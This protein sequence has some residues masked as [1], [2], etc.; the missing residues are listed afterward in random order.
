MGLFQDY[1]GK[2]IISSLGT[3]WSKQISMSQFSIHDLSHIHV[4]DVL[5]IEND[6]D[7]AAYVPELQL[8][9]GDLDFFQNQFVIQHIKLENATINLLKDKGEEKYNFQFLFKKSQNE[10]DIISNYHVL[11]ENVELINCVFN[12]R[13]L[14]NKNYTQTFDYQFFN[15]SNINGLFNNFSISNKGIF[16]PKNRLFFL[17]D[18][19]IDVR[20]LY[21]EFTLDY[22][23]IFVENIELKTLKSRLHLASFTYDLKS[24]DYSDIVYSLD[25]VVGNTCLTDVTHFYPIPIFM[26]TV[27]SFLLILKEINVYFL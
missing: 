21:C 17:L 24:N 14:D 3:E 4:F 9:L 16:L 20:D 27:L 10:N 19:A 7:T 26:D 1:L 6:G 11:I 25:S 2:K 8:K 5:L 13:I 12:H 18:K 22:N 23:N 15:I